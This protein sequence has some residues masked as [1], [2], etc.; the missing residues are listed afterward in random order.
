MAGEPS[1]ILNTCRELESSQLIHSSDDER[2]NTNIGYLITFNL[3]KVLE[4]CCEKLTRFICY[5]IESSENRIANV[6][7][8]KKYDLPN[9]NLILTNAYQQSYWEKLLGES[10]KQ[11]NTVVLMNRKKLFNATTINRYETLII[12]INFLRSMSDANSIFSSISFSRVVYHNVTL[13]PSIL[14]QHVKSAFKWVVSS[15]DIEVERLTHNLP[16]SIKKNIVIRD[17]ECKSIDCTTSV[18]ILSCRPI[19]S[20]TLDGLVERIITD[21][22]DT[23]NIKRV[24]K[25][26]SSPDIRTE[27]DIIKLVLRRLNND[28][29]LV[30]EN[31]ICIN[32]M[33]YANLEDKTNRIQKIKKSRELIHLKKEELINRMTSNNI[34]FICYS[35]MEVKTVL[36]CCANVVCLSC[37]N[38]WLHQ[39]NTC[40]LCKVSKV[41]Y[42]IVTEDE[43]ESS[44]CMSMQ[45]VLSHT[46]SIFSNFSILCKDILIKKPS[47][48]IVVVGS[49]GT[50]FLNKF[51]DIVRD[52]LGVEYAYVG[53][54]NTTLKKIYSQF[55][56]G[57]IRLLFVNQKKI[58]YPIMFNRAIDVIYI[59]DHT[60]T[61]WNILP[62]VKNVWTVRYKDCSHALNHV[63]E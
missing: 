22:I 37:I 8:F 31:E 25:H 34:C 4:L 7:I 3:K 36:K 39:Q 47:A 29:R 26:L 18:E 54:N 38:K 16:E 52:T 5:N 41:S 49:D 56:S 57:S 48:S 12:P 15:D 45:P 28:L 62:N 17:P 14:K 6:H 51:I 1:C 43:K 21:S 46:N 30:D 40:P 59:S 19:E 50:Q 44:E 11:F 33:H 23:Y 20:V 55:E 27:K 53:G 63:S 61:V 60:Q 58:V 10:T 2:Y 24:I 9:K 35:P 42:Y 32:R 13:T